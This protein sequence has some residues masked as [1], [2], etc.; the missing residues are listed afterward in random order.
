MIGYRK[1]KEQEKKGKQMKEK[2]TIVIIAIIVVILLSIGAGIGIYQYQQKEEE[3]QKEI[4]EKEI[5]SINNVTKI[6]MDIQAKGNYGKVEK[7]IKEDM[8]ECY[9]HL[10]SLGQAY[11]NK[12]VSQTFSID[13]LKKDGPEFKQ[14][15][16]AIAEVRQT[17][18]KETKELENL[19]SNDAIQEK[20]KK[21]KTNNKFKGIYQE[22]LAFFNY[23]E[24]GWQGIQ[25]NNK[26]FLAY[27]DKIEEILTYLEE[28]A[29]E[30]SI[31]E[32]KMNYRNITF[33][34]KYYQLIEELKEI[35]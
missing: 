5:S 33:L 19:L 2:K 4:F 7:Q 14:T 16:K 26:R 30:W 32:D 35:R 9:E 11:N 27:L 22:K 6:N 15:K 3:K 23:D 18:E 10:N 21:L 24:K 31:Q 12:I 29:N 13:N 25:E 17:I 28:N 20:V 1:R 34:T 8:K